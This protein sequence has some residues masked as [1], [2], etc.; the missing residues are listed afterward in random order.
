[1]SDAT[2]HDGAIARSDHG[3]GTES[4]QFDLLADEFAER[5]RRGESPSIGEFE[6][7]FPECAEKIRELLPAVAMMEQLKRQRRRVQGTEAARATPERLGEFRIIRELGRGGMGIVYEAVQESLDRHVA[8]KV[9]PHHGLLDAKRLQRFRHEA[10]AVARLHHTN[11]VPVFGVGEHDGLPYYVMQYIRGR[12]LDHLLETWRQGQ[13]PRGADRWRFVARLGVQAAE[14]LRY[15]HDQGILHRDIKPANLLLDEHQAVWITDFGLAKLTGREDLTASGDVI[16]TLRYLAPEAL[17]GETDQRSDVYSLGLTLYELLTLT[18]PFG[19]LSPSE[20]LRRVTEAQPTRPRTLDPTIPRDLETIVLKAIAREPDHRYPAADALADDLKRFLDDRPIR[21]RRATATERLWRWCRRNRTTA[22]L[23]TTAAGALVL[24]AVVGWVGYASTMRAL[25]GEEKRRI[26]A[27][28]ATRRA[29]ENVALSLAAFEDLFDTLSAPGRPPLATGAAT[30]RQVTSRPPMPGPPRP[31]RSSLPEKDAALLQSVLT[32]YDRFAQRNATNPRLHGEAARA[33][34]KV[35]FLYQ[36]LDR[37]PE[38]QEAY[39]SAAA[40]F[41]GLAA[42]FPDVPEYRF[43]LAETYAMADPRS[44]DPTSLD[45]LERR[46]RQALTLIEPLAAESPGRLEYASARARVLEKL[47][48]TLHRLHRADDAEASYRRAIALDEALVARSP[49]PPNVPIALA[50]K[51]EALAT[52]LLE[53]G[54]RDEARQLLDAAAADLRSIATDEPMH[55]GTERAIAERCASL[56]KTF[57]GLGETARAEEMASWALK[58]R[59]RPPGDRPGA[60]DRG[61]SG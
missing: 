42:R 37:D 61:F 6:D 26:E 3:D 49:M 27:E 40:K 18:S 15:A 36:M 8:L 29:E 44:T 4:D 16:G 56:A 43:D 23:T 55:S 9:I 45:R 12:G 57:E 31:S 51:R 35:G 46:L 17:R 19:E 38:A 54:R 58:V 52:L 50:A 1:M 48:A 14:A 28:T 24:A 25:G 2:L 33:Q 53:A 7:R 39:A 30:G 5:C 41:E 21:A 11:I 20:L 60:T 22:A 47:G 13:C 34:R 10:Q 59:S 32:F